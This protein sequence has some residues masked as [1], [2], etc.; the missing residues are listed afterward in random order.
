MR[1]QFRRPLEA[2]KRVPGT[3]LSSCLRDHPIGCEIAA[4]RMKGE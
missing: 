3:T 1:K 4:R 2:E